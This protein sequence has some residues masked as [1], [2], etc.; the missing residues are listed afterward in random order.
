MNKEFIIKLLVILIFIGSVGFDCFAQSLGNAGTVSGTVTDPNGAV[1]SGAS[2]SIANAVTGFSSNNDDRCGRL[3]H[4][5]AILPP[6]NYQIK[7][8]A[9]GFQ[10]ATQNIV[11]RNSVPLQVP[12]SLMSAAGR[13]KTSM[14]RRCDQYRKYSDDADQ[15]RSVAASKIAALSSPGNGLSDAVT[16]TSPGVVADSN[17]LFHPLGDHAQTQFSLDNQPITDQQ[18]KAFST[19]MPVNAI[20]SL[21]VITGA[22]PAEFGDKSSLVVNAITRSG[23]NSPKPFGSLTSSYGRFKTY[24]AGSDIRFRKFSNSAI[25]RHLITSDPIVFS[26]RRNLNTLHNKGNSVECFQS[27]RL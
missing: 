4:F 9:G 8:S 23:L 7:V 21:E 15:S 13:A 20:Q 27:F 24:S 17:G 14:C 10:K 11:V 26:I 16:L 19:Q 22:T 3:L 6:N 12:I 18:S 25:L 1:V 2:V 5:S